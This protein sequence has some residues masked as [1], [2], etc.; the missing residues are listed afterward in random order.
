LGQ[1]SLAA[2]PRE[3]GK[4]AYRIDQKN[5]LGKLVPNTANTG[6]SGKSM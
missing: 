5:F 6:V 2:I 1:I 3:R 4:Y